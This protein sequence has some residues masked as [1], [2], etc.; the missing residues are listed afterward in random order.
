FSKRSSYL[1]SVSDHSSFRSRFAIRRNNHRNLC[2]LLS[3]TCDG[4]FASHLLSP[5]A[6][7][8]KTQAVM[9]IT[10]LKTV[11]I[12]REFQSYFLCIAQQVRLKIP[13][14]SVFEG[15][16][17]CLLTDVHQIF[18]PQRRKIRSAA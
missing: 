8:R 1:S 7:S 11:A 18:L 13:C 9:S 5:L 4:Q 16:G 3:R 12:V 17:Q 6:H 15:V 14:M 10:Q 2:A